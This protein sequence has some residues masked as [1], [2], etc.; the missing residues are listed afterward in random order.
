MTPDQLLQHAD[1]GLPWTER[2]SDL[3]D[4]SLD[5]AYRDALTVRSLRIARGERPV[6]FKVGFTNRGIWPVYQVYAP[7]W[8]TVWAH[9]VAFCDGEG[10]LDLRNTCEPRIEPEAVFGFRASPPNDP[11]M[12]D[13]FDA[14]EWVAPG[15]EIVQSH[16]PGWKFA[17]PDTV[18]DGGLHARLLVGARRS[19]REIADSA[20]NLD[21]QLAG[22]GVVLARDGAAVEQGRGLNV[23]DGPMQALWHF[24]KELQRCPGAPS[25]QPGDLVTTGTWT[26]A[27]PVTPGQTWHAAFDAPLTPLTLR[28]E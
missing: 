16:L 4:Y 3:A 6:G 18:A 14:L 22:A 10:T 25:L 1:Q 9:S 15:F 24:V 26:D 12:A 8:G 5:A 20:V 2:Q 11:T 27:W 7:I 13:L 17:A 28:L 21:A 19:V 23:L